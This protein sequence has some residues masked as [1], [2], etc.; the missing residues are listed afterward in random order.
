MGVRSLGNIRNESNFA[1]RFG[2]VEKKRS[3]FSAAPLWWRR[4]KTNDVQHSATQA[5]GEQIIQTVAQPLGFGEER[6][7]ILRC[8]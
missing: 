7:E 1:H 2:S 6:W 5:Y 3:W 4:S 8:G